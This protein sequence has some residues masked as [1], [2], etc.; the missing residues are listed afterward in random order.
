M[1]DTLLSSQAS[2]ATRGTVSRQP[3]GA[4]DQA[5]QTETRMSN[6]NPSPGQSHDHPDRQTA[7]RRLDQAYQIR[8]PKSTP[9]HITSHHTKQPRNQSRPSDAASHPQA[10]HLTLP[11]NNPQVKPGPKRLH[12]ADTPYP[13]PT[14]RKKAKPHP[15]KTTQKPGQP[16]KDSKN[17]T[18]PPAKCKIGPRT[19]VLRPIRDAGDVV[20]TQCDERR[21]VPRCTPHHACDVLT[22]DDSSLYRTD[23]LLAASQECHPTGKEVLTGE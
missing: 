17:N 23:R 10:A 21:P 19:S 15:H 8:S 13:W 3:L 9:A 11:I 5:Y 7:S 12:T 6:P 22:C 4:P 2:H 20:L 14:Q 16:R 1:K 18:H